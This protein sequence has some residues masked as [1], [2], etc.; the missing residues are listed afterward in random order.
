[1]AI[2]LAIEQKSTE[3]DQTPQSVVDTFSLNADLPHL[4]NFNLGNSIV[5]I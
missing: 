3:K 2:H 1:M 5:E 4:A